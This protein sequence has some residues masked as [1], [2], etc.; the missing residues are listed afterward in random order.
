MTF[1]RPILFG[2]LAGL[3]VG[4]IYVLTKVPRHDRVWQPHLSR[5]PQ[6]TLDDGKFS[7]REYRDWT[8]SQSDVSEQKWI[9]LGER[10]ISDV[11]RAHLLLEPHPGLAVMAHTLILFEFA[12][13]EMVGLT[14]EA[15]KELDESYSP[16]LGALRK[17]E[18]IYQWATPRDLLTRRAVWMQRD[19][20]LYK[21]ELSQDEIELYLTTVLEK[22][23]ALEERPRFYSTL[24]SNCTNE[25][26]KSAGLRWQPAFLLTGRSDKALYGQARIANESSFEDV[27]ASAKVDDRIRRAADMNQRAF[28]RELL[29][30]NASLR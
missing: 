15:R 17:Y 24:H 2:I 14:V 22:T 11:R 29:V 18:L 20:Y 3:C 13:G 21:L 5:L 26:A 9:D 12:D 4:L 19:L 6:V 10:Q 16:F 30:P 23:I 27:K 28:H 1:A 25:L 7:I 8:Y